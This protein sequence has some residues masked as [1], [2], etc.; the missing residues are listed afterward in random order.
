MDVDP[1]DLSLSRPKDKQSV[2]PDLFANEESSQHSTTTNNNKYFNIDN[3][4]KNQEYNDFLFAQK[5]QQQFNLESETGDGSNAA[6]QFRTRTQS[7]KGVVKRK[8][9]TQR[10]RSLTVSSQPTLR[11]AYRRAASKNSQ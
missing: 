2:S 11:E 7:S 3:L 8:S 1:V 6:Y 10:K 5:L 9:S 4:E